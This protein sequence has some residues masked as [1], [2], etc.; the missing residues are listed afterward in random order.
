MHRRFYPGK[1][2]D[3]PPGG[4]SWWFKQDEIHQATHVHGGPEFLPWHR[5]LTNRFEQLLRQINPQLSLHYWDFKDDPRSAPDGK[6]GTVNLFDSNFMGSPGIQEGV[7]PDG[8]PIGEPWLTAGFYD[9]L[10]GTAGHP[11]GREVSGNPVDPPKLVMR[12]SNYAGPAPAPLITANQ[13]NHI[14]GLQDFGPGIAQ[15]H[16]DDSNFVNNIKPNYFRTAWEDIHNRAHTYFADI[17]P[18][19]AFRDPFVFL[20]H[21]NVDRIYARWQL[22]PMH[23][24][25]LDPN[26]VYGSEGNTDVDVIAVGVH[27]V[28]NLTHNVEPWST[29]HGEFHDIRPWERTHENEGVPHTYHDISVVTP[30]VYDTNP[31][32][33]AVAG[34]ITGRVTDLE[35]GTGIADA[36]VLLRSG[37]VILPGGGN[38][39]QVSTDSMGLYT[40]PVVP[41]GVYDLSAVQSGFVPDRASVTVAARVTPKDFHLVRA[42]AFTIKGMVADG[43]G[44]PIQGATVTLVE[45]A[46]I[47]GIIKAITDSRGLYSLTENPGSYDGDYTVTADASGF[48]PKT[49]TIAKIQNGATIPLP[50]TLAKLGSITGVVFDDTGGRPIAGATLTIGPASATTDSAGQYNSTMLAP[51]AYNITVIASGFATDHASATVTEGL[52]TTVNFRLVKAVTGVIAGNVS[53]DDGPIGATVT[54]ETVWG[55][56]STDTDFDGNYTLSGLPAGQTQVSAA[57]PR[58]RSQQQL[59]Q[60][61]GGQTERLVFTLDIVGRREPQPRF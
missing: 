43:R 2:D 58:H 25:R 29:G 27:S 31:P 61:I 6:G 4:V 40:T 46:A 59:V 24:E 13:E 7:N 51:G 50:F 20:L 16:S 52:A 54:A 30:L 60:L 14:L 5:E 9:P 8:G 42:R 21:S 44:T 10:A 3:T 53:D 12:P 38:T 41:P 15:N 57:A 19:D 18:H 33:P 28:Q 56:F 39:L 32:R 45:N 49:I 23:P 1:R 36:S 22:D 17:S 34:V 11:Q 35:A 55:P 47:P 48:A 26:T 37:S